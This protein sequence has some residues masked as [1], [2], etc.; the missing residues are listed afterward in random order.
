MC[1]LPLSCTH[2]VKTGSCCIPKKSPPFPGV[3]I[4][5]EAAAAAAAVAVGKRDLFG[6]LSAEKK[7]YSG[8]RKE[9]L[10]ASI[11]RGVDEH[12]F[13]RRDVRNPAF[14]GFITNTHLDSR[15]PGCRSGSRKFEKLYYS[16]TRVSYLQRCWGRRRERRRRQPSSLSDH[17]NPGRSIYEQRKKSI[18]A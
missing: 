15:I 7:I 5:T 6:V 12:R 16:T 4:R 1:C 9:S 11:P 10:S 13:R 17:H 18:K 2:F 14:P 3:I 8:C